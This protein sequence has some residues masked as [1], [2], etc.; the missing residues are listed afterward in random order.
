MWE[1]LKDKINELAV[2]SKDKNI[3]EPYKGII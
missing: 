1:Y 2:N 3:R